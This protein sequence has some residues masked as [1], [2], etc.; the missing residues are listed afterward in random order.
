MWVYHFASTQELTF[1]RQTIKVPSVLKMLQYKP[2]PSFL[3]QSRELCWFLDSSSI[4]GLTKFCVLMYGL[5]QRTRAVWVWT[6][7]TNHNSYRKWLREINPSI[8]VILSDTT[9]T[10]VPMISTVKKKI[11]P[12]GIRSWIKNKANAQ[13]TNQKHCLEQQASTNELKWLL[14]SLKY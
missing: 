7:N 1:S 3:S 9:P 6:L 4:V 10:F 11:Y 8:L 14:V 5:Y 13:N 2:V 12:Y